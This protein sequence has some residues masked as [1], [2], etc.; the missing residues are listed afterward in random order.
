MRESG[1]EMRNDHTPGTE[2][3]A[4]M[5][6]NDSARPEWPTVEGPRCEAVWATPLS[7]L[8]FSCRLME[9]C[10]AVSVTIVIVWD[11]LITAAF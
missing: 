4:D 6:Q 9:G 8:Q 7:V 5:L 1:A 2:D 11:T 10:Q 3:F